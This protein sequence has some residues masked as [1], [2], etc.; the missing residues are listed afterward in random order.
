MKKTYIN[1]CIMF[2]KVDSMLMQNA[3]L[4]KYNEEKDAG[5]A[6]GKSDFDTPKSRSVW[7]NEED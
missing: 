1:P 4:T 3:S 2:L 6:L 7:D 5:D